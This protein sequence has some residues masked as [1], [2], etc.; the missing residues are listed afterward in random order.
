M[1]RWGDRCVKRR[2]LLFM[3]LRAGEAGRQLVCDASLPR[4]GE[5]GVAYPPIDQI[6]SERDQGRTS[7]AAAATAM[8]VGVH[9]WSSRAVHAILV[10]QSQTFA[11]SRGGRNVCPVRV[12]TL[13]FSCFECLTASA[14]MKSFA[15]CHLNSGDSRR[16]CD[17]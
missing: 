10:L 6:R 3:R 14:S 15:T 4:V 13:A 1:S 12:V 17:A 16:V 11:R 5:H 9:Y 8:S 7:I 2:C